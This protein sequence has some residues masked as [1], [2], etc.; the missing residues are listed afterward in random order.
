M[1]TSVPVVKTRPLNRP[2]VR[3]LTRQLLRPEWITSIVPIR[4]GLMI[5]L[6]S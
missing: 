6:K 4:D 3:E 5:A 2:G 1:W